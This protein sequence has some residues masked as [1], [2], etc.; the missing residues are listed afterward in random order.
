[1]G[2]LQHLVEG[3]TLGGAT[4]VLAASIFHF[5]QHSIGEAKAAM[6]AAGVQVRPA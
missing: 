5:G 1:V 4:G 3:V 2:T 6:A